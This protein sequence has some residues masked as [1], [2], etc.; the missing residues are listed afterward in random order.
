MYG[1]NRLV[2]V[3]RRCRT[4]SVAVKYDRNCQYGFGLRHCQKLYGLGED[5]EEACAKGWWWDGGGRLVSA[6]CRRR[7][8]TAIM[9]MAWRRRAVEKCAPNQ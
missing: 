9:R 6:T 8:C 2:L 5:A 3:S 4:S 1:R 7:M